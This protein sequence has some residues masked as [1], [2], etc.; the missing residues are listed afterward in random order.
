MS[1][2]KHTDQVKL[3][4]FFQMGAGYVLDFSDRTFRDFILRVVGIDINDE[5]YKAG[6]TSKANRLRT[7]WSLES[8]NIVS[9]LIAEM[10]IYWRD[11]LAQE[12]L[13]EKLYQETI[14][15]AYDLKSDLSDHAEAIQPNEHDVNFSA[16]AKFIRDAIKRNEVQSILDRLHTFLMKY[17]RNLLLKYNIEY[18]KVTQLQGLC[19]LYVKHLK[20]NKKIQSA[21]TERI[22][23]SSISILDAFNNVRNEQSFAHDNTLLEQSEA[24]L[25]FKNISA[26]I[27]FISNLEM[28]LNKAIATSEEKEDDDLPF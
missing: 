10:A 12:N 8:N 3:E 11:N 24:R 9:Q 22:L 15:I 14:S 6:G 17:F 4:R 23:K 19:S 20:G 1:D 28:E 16:L 27:E 2:L 26:T 7:F 18:E 21:M 13:D 25:I 5:K